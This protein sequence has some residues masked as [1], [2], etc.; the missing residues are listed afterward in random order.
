[1]PRR[2][3]EA[4]VAHVLLHAV[5]NVD[6]I[7]VVVVVIVVFIIIFVVVVV[8]VTLCVSDNV[9]RMYARRV[10]DSAR[11]E[12]EHP[13]RGGITSRHAS[14]TQHLIPFQNSRG[15]ITDMVVGSGGRL[16]GREP[17]M[18]SSIATLFCIPRLW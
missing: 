11:L 17:S 9:S 15:I 13:W 10:V 8:V 18:R 12:R 2:W 5:V 7:V 6:D 3:K 14:R 4:E 16:L 1:M